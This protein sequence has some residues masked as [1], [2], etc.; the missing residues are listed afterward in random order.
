[1]LHFPCQ[2]GDVTMAAYMSN[3]FPS[4]RLS[5]LAL[6]TVSFLPLAANA[7]G[8]QALDRATLRGIKSGAIVIDR[9]A[10]ELVRRGLT[11]AALQSRIENRLRDAAMPLDA[12]AAELVGRRVIRVRV[13]NAP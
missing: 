13:A 2:R 3:T 6:L 12:G 7:A 1:M 8:D 9:R 11:Q 5:I 4:T 10:P